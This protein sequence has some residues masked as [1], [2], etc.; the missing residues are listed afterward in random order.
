MGDWYSSNAA[1]LAVECIDGFWPDKCF[2]APVTP[3][4]LIFYVMEL[5]RS[6]GSIVA[7]AVAE[8]GIGKE[9]NHG[10]THIS[11]NFHHGNLGPHFG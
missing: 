11:K 6:Y 5:R 4:L 3:Y 7:E 2:T 10:P 1:S 9:S 8:G